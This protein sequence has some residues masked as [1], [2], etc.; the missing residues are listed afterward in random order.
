MVRTKLVTHVGVTYENSTPL[1]ELEKAKIAV[2]AG[3][4]IIA[5][6]SIGKNALK[7]IELL[8]TELQVPVTASPG[9]YLA[10]GNGNASIDKDCTKE[11]ILNCIEKIINA[12]VS[13]ITVH[14]T[15]N[16]ALIEQMKRKNRTFAFTSRM[17]GYILEY[18]NT[19]ANEN[20][21]YLY[22]DDIINICARKNIKLSFGLALRSPTVTN[23]D[24]FDDLFKAE[25]LATKPLIKKC[26]DKGVDCLLE[27]G[28]HI[29]INKMPEWVSF[30]KKN[31]FGVKMRVLVVPTDRA[32]GHDCVSGAIAAAFMAFYGVDY[33]CTV[34]RAEH[35]SMPLLE[36]IK[37]SVIYFRIALD[38]INLNLKEERDVALSRAK[39]GC[40]LPDIF[41]HLIDNDGAKEEVKKRVVN[42]GLENDFVDS[43]E[44]CTMCGDSCPL[45]KFHHKELN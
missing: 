30:V 7:T 36:D 13:A 34:T 44:E 4:D 21:F 9:Y 19:T 39:G 45:K 10:T 40:H 35:I 42:Y 26:I 16:K 17:G 12:G 41:N 2:Q 31:C 25:I 22:I 23:S 14:A 18:I 6:A 38:S 3:T 32:M 15:F 11:D 27:C 1:Q 37:E 28:G 20:P 5:D 33:I 24:G 8:C 43:N 29:S